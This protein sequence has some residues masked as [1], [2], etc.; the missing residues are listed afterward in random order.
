MKRR[1]II[2]ILLFAMGL[3]FCTSS[4]EDMLTADLDRHQDTPAQ[5]T[6]YTY[7]GVL[8]SLQGISE[9][10]VILGECRGDLVSGTEYISDSI[11]SICDF[12][13][14]KAVDGSNRYLRARD[15]YHVINSCN[16]Y[17]AYADTNRVTGTNNKYMIKEYAQ[18]EAIRAWVYLQLVQV[19]G[20][21]PFYTRPLL[22]TADIDAFI[23]NPSSPTASRNNLPDLLGP[24]LEMVKDVPL[25]NYDTYG[26]ESDPICHSLLCT[27]PVNLVLGDIY[28]LRGTK[29]DCTKAAEYY[30]EY[31]E[32]NMATPSRSYYCYGYQSMITNTPYYSMNGEYYFTSTNKPTS[33]SELI[34]VIPTNKNKLTGSVQRGV[35]SLFGYTPTISVADT[36]NNATIILTPNYEKELDPSAGYF[37]LCKSQQYEEYIGESDKLDQLSPKVAEGLGDAR[38]AWIEEWNSSAGQQGK[39]ITKQNP[40]GAFNT[41]YPYIYRKGSVWLRFAEAIN[42]AGFPGYAF[43]ILKDGVCNNARWFATQPSQ[44]EFTEYQYFDKADKDSVIRDRQELLD[45]GLEIDSIP[46]LESATNRQNPA[47]Q[48]I[49]NYISY[50]EAMRAKDAGFLYFNRSSFYGEP[51]RRIH[52]RRSNTS[53]GF[54]ITY[55]TVEGG[56]GIGIHSRGCGSLRVDEPN[57]VFNFE[58]AVKKANPNV[59][60]P[61]DLAQQ[62]DVIEAVENLIVDEFALETAFEGNRFFDLM[63]VSLRRNDPMFLAKKVANRKGYEDATLLNRLSDPANWYFKLPNR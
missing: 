22:T 58:D 12:D 51:D 54:N 18:V 19:Y 26:I 52:I 60:D 6:L 5:D 17:L 46:V 27:F 59:T 48:V 4:C 32:E 40:Y 53:T 31:L 49:C 29:A 47:N 56:C 41:V 39:F 45:E 44:F 9:R 57:S 30:Y 37:N 8:K 34:T 3:S 10:Y 1:S 21:V 63:R 15:Y 24:K 16:S 20:E 14:E 25:P 23:H 42:R 13:R 2:H 62:E 38:Q 7:W 11:N 61:Y 33:L 43:A 55:K 36:S 28:L 50:D 35:N